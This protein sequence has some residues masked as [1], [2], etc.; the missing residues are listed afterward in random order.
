MNSSEFKP[1][2][3]LKIA[4]MIINLTQYRLSKLSS[5]SQVTI[6]KIEN[7]IV[8][9]RD[10]TILKIEKIVGPVDWERTFSEGFIQR[11]KVN[12]EL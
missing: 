1:I 2:Y 3:S 7:G 10:K 4:R 12:H 11:R 5:I 9:P 8:R 6:S